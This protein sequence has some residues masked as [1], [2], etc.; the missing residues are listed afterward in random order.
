MGIFKVLFFGNGKKHRKNKVL[1]LRPKKYTFRVAWKKISIFLK[2]HAGLVTILLLLLTA[3]FFAIRPFFIKAS[4][5]AFYP[6]SCLGGWENVHNAEGEPQVFDNSNPAIF[7]EQNSAYLNNR[8]S[9]MF[10]GSFTGTL[11]QNTQ[12]QKITL[13]LSWAIGKKDVITTVV[14]TSSTPISDSTS[15]D[16]VLIDLNDDFTSSAR[17]AENPILNGESTTTSTSTSA[18]SSS[19]PETPA[20]T[21]TPDST[22]TPTP[23]LPQTPTS[24]PTPVESPEPTVETPTPTEAPATPAPVESPAPAEAPTPSPT[25]FMNFLMPKVYAADLSNETSTLPGT[26]NIVETATTSSLP[27]AVVDPVFTIL[28]TIDGTKWNT[29]GTVTQSEI[30]SKDFDIPIDNIQDQK[31][32]S[33]IQINIQSATTIDQELSVYLDGMTLAVQYETPPSEITVKEKTTDTGKEVTVSAPNEDP[34]HPLVDVLASTKIPKIY[35]VGEEDKIHIKWKNNGNQD[36]TFHAYDKD[37]D[38]Y[39]DYVEWDRASPVGP[40]FRNNFCFKSISTRCG[41][42]HYRRYL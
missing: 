36:M 27:L 26:T 40:N 33:N 18:D 41:S 21:P 11:P 25:S 42:K 15:T 28:Y 13:H 9:Q 3:G 39:L 7:N 30:G 22:P 5:A 10:C 17:N 20:P 23:E 4:V 2:K 29:L 35:K 38:G 12:P 19:A 31:D 6:S 16:S 14:A 24:I 1:D 32:L 34:D 8:I 37:N